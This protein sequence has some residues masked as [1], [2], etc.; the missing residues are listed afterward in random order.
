MSN[1]HL[2]ALISGKE[3]AEYFGVTYQYFRDRLCKA[4]GFPKPVRSMIWR[5]KDINGWSGK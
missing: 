5:A 4:H 3:L 1:Q 2:D